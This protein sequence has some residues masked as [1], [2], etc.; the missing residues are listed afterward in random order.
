MNRHFTIFVLFTAAYFMSYFFRSANAVIAPT[1]AKE[2]ALTAAD[3]GLMT[4]LFFATF[5]AVQTPVGVG[6]D[7]WGPRWVTPL[8]ML[9][10]VVGALIFAVAPS[11]PV[12]ALGRA[13]IGMGMA[14]VLMGSLKIF[15]QWFS[16]ERFATVSGLLVG[17]GA[18]G[19]LTAATP[20]AWLAAQIG[21]RNIFVI[22]ALLTAFFAIAIMLW[23]RNTPPG[24]VW[25]GGSNNAGALMDIF[26]K[27]QVWRITPMI[28]FLAGGLM[29]FHGLWA[30][31][32][33]FDVYG[34]SPIAGGNI[35][36]WLGIGVTIGYGASGWLADQFGLGRILA[37]GS[38][39]YI[40]SL[41]GLALLPPL[42]VVVVLYV[43]FGIT[44][45][46]NVMLMAQARQL[47][48]LAMTGKAVS[49]VNMFGIGGTFILQW[50]MGLIINRFPV[51]AAGHYP[52]QAYTTALLFLAI[53]ALLAYLW[54]LPL[55]R[56][57][58][59]AVAAA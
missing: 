16:V 28:F 49:A 17:I 33:L 25:T 11:F 26:R 12:L 21:W 56:T 48:P 31:P 42:P 3:L 29:G 39:L 30:G 5:A 2:M 41:F 24:V 36:L 20:L 52:P 15:S 37:I 47:F 18:L 59:A 46:F 51:D 4:S 8:L 27:P 44:G 1:L 34:L 50:V 6:L 45:G 13:L 7:R 58:Q 32:Y 40:L 10:G 38:L 54:Y 57:K 22:G 14:G 35:L 53:G 23:A 19:S 9:V 55:V 43:L